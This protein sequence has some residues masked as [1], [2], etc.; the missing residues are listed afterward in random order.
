VA[1][2]THTC[3]VQLCVWG[4]ARTKR[5][6]RGGSTVAWRAAS[7][8]VAPMREGGDEQGSGT[9]P[10]LTR[11]EAGPALSGCPAPAQPP[12]DRHSWRSG[13]PHARPLPRLRFSSAVGPVRPSWLAPDSGHTQFHQTGMCMFGSL[14][15]WPLPR[16]GQTAGRPRQE[17][18]GT[19]PR[20]VKDVPELRCRPLTG[21]TQ[22]SW[23]GMCSSRVHQLSTRRAGKV[24]VR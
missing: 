21:T 17:R 20:G 12:R 1:T 11:R 24:P 4:Q 23:E 10:S 16:P 9:R 15:H 22:G 13:P 14:A 19:A 8:R 5:A 7:G 3:L 18:R 6:D 2:D